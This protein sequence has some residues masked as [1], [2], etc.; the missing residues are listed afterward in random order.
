MNESQTDVKQES[1]STEDVTNQQVNEDVKHEVPYSRFKEVNDK[2]KSSASENDSLSSEIN[3]MKEDILIKEG[4]KD[5]VIANLKAEISA[6]KKDNDTL[7]SYVIDERDRLLSALPEE[8]REKYTNVDLVALRDIV[9][10]R[11][12]L[13]NK[14]IGVDTSRGGTS[15]NP[16]KAFHEMSMDEKSDPATWQSY[17]SSFKRK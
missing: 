14:K 6:M 7:S 12:E 8:K 3:S 13:L 11:E 9:Q 15:M 5:D 10:E 16:P 2:L 1:Q 4:K 17:L